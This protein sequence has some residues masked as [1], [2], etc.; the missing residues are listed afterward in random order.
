MKQSIT[1]YHRDQ[2]GVWV[3][4]LGCG[5]DR[6]VRHRPPFV[7]RPWVASPNGRDAMLGQEL[8]CAKCDRGEPVDRK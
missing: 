1:G 7:N 2:E 6:H 3:A 4:E 5:H 8:D